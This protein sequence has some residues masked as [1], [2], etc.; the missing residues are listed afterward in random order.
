VPKGTPSD[1]IEKINA[2]ALKAVADPEVKVWGAERRG[3]DAR[4]HRRGVRRPPAQPDR[5]VDQAVKAEWHQN[6]TF[7]RRIK[8]GLLVPHLDGSMLCAEIRSEDFF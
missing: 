2:A 8:R 4:H 6:D 7:R 5:H 1:V 3:R